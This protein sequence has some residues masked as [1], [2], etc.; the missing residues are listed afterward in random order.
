[1]GFPKHGESQDAHRVTRYF[2]AAGLRRGRTG[3]KEHCTITKHCHANVSIMH[4]EANKPDTHICAIERRIN[5]P[6]WG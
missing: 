3:C 2:V 6:G 4:G 5:G 1:M